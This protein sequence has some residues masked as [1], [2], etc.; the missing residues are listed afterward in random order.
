MD[1]Q[2]LNTSP[3]KAVTF[4]GTSKLPS[5]VHPL[6]AAAP[7]ESSSLSG[8][9]VTELRY[10][11][12]L[13]ADA[14]IEV[15]VAGTVNC[16]SFEQP[17]NALAPIDSSESGKSTPSSVLQLLKPSTPIDVVPSPRLTCLQPLNM[18]FVTSAIDEPSGNDTA[19]IPLKASFPMAVTACVSLRLFTPVQ[20]ENAA[21]PTSS[22]AGLAGTVTDVS[23]TQP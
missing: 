12:L 7:M 1:L 2:P 19:S 5:D 15:T 17:E 21:A 23:D 8:T 3:S 13:N 18:S 20:P 11:Q 14:P 10:E 6:K 22:E 4:E 9:N 16:P